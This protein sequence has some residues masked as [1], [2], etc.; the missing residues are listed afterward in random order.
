[1]P[2]KVSSQPSLGRLVQPFLRGDIAPYQER[3]ASPTHSPSRMST[4]WEQRYP[5]PFPVELK[6]RP[7]SIFLVI[8]RPVNEIP[9][10][11]CGTTCGRISADSNRF[12][13]ASSRLLSTRSCRQGDLPCHAF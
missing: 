11:P 3:I 5:A 2:S 10:R 13:P 6:A 4:Y 8:C 9:L 1:P 12:S 7:P